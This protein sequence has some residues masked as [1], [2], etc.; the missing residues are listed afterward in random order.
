MTPPSDAPLTP[1]EIEQRQPAVP[2]DDDQ[3]DTDLPAE[4]LDPDELEQRQEVGWDE[5]DQRPA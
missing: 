1:D 2:E 3:V 5:D 4:P